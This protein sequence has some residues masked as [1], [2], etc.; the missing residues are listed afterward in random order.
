MD[1]DDDDDDGDGD[2]DDDD[3]DDNDNN[4]NKEEEG[5][6]KGKKKCNLYLGS[7]VSLIF[8]ERTRCDDANCQNGGTCRK[9]FNYFIC[10]C[11]PGFTGNSCQIS[12]SVRVSVCMQVMYVCI[13]VCV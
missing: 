12:T 3:D 5:K 9:W 6:G 13:C 1:D 8:A 10:T 2:D 4:N 7:V 11:L